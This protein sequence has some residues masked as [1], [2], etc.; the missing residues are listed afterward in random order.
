MD[1]REIYANHAERYHELVSAEDVD[2]HL[3]RQLA[4][5]FPAPRGTIV[6]VGAGTGRVSKQLLELGAHVVAVEPAA[7]MLDVARCQ[8]AEH[9]PARLEVRLGDGRALPLDD[10]AAS[11]AVAGWVFGHFRYWQEADWQEH[12]Q[13]ALSEMERVVV[14]GGVIAVIETLGTGQLVAAPP[15]ERLAE[16]YRWLE[17]QGFVRRQF[18]TDYAFKDVTSAVDCLGFFFGA[19]MAERVR[20]HGWARVPEWTGL[21]SRSRPG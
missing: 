19:E 21:W 17:V 16:Y 5:V 12:V 11:G 13:Q 4:A 20:T 9:I 15:N 7:A 8:L 2:G 14:P 1:F 6:D 3:A 18:P 10:G